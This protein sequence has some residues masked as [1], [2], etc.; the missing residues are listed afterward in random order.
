MKPDSSSLHFP[1]VLFH[2][3]LTLTLKLCPSQEIRNGKMVGLTFSSPTLHPDLNVP[4]AHSTPPAAT[5]RD[6][7]SPPYPLAGAP[8][9]PLP[10]SLLLPHLEPLPG[11]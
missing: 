2:S 7:C 8:S 9:S 5:R 6:A 4:F 1:P 11:S 10:L 3:S